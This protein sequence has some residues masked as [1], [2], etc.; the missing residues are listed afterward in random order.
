MK[1]NNK[2]IYIGA[3]VLV[4]VIFIASLISVFNKHKLE[5][6]V[7][8]NEEVSTPLDTQLSAQNTTKINKRVARSSKANVNTANTEEVKL[9]GIS[10]TEAYMKY[11]DGHII[12][13]S[14]N[15]QSS[16]YRIVLKNG[17]ELMLD[18][19]STKKEIVSI[20]DARYNLG[21]YG[22]KV[23]RLKEVKTPST[24]LIDCTTSQNVNTLIIE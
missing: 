20:G 9:N 3:A 4:T 23:I 2:E 8:A 24:N 11:N 19:R 15:C 1:K 17:S 12:Q 6:P 22:F 10:Y 14:D 18:N 16:P 5:A 7:N 13:F 21:A